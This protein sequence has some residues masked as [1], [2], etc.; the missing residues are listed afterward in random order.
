MNVI[1]HP[2]LFKVR[3]F[4]IFFW[5]FGLDYK[6]TFRLKPSVFISE[7]CHVV[8]HYH[9]TTVEERRTGPGPNC[10]TERTGASP[11]FLF[12][13]GSSTL[14]HMAS[15]IPRLRQSCP[16]IG[17]F[18]NKGI[19]IFIHESCLIVQSLRSYNPLSIL[20]TSLEY[21]RNNLFRTCDVILG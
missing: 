12:R 21:K 17:Q 20:F 10:E 6:Q 15:F 7:V 8:V 2:D 3:N 4:Q 19:L 16:I 13:V 9:V 1:I 14:S 5:N 11:P 18:K